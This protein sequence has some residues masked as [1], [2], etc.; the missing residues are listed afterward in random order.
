M[1]PHAKLTKSKRWL[2]TGK[3]FAVC[4]EELKDALTDWH[5]VARQAYSYSMPTAKRMVEISRAYY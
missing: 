5:A 1:K 2:V 4:R 3:G